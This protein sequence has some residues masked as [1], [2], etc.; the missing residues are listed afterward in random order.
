MAQFDFEQLTVYQKAIEFA[1]KAYQLTWVFPNQERYGLVDQFRRAAT[2]IALN[3]AE[4]SGQSFREFHHALRIARG[5]VHECVAILEISSR[6]GYLSSD[7]RLLAYNE[8][9]ELSKMLTALMRV[10]RQKK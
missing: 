8:C 5:S 3:I 6:S 2:S 4:G 7:Q 10:L 1:D 9:S